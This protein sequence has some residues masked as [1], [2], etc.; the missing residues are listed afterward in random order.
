MTAIETF[1]AFFVTAFVLLRWGLLALMGEYFANNMFA[2]TPFTVHTS[3]WYFGN[4]VLMAGAILALAV[5]D[6]GP[7][8]RGSGCGRLVCWSEGGAIPQ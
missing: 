5:W 2:Q 7:L 8:Q 4:S 1:L 6:S 3:E